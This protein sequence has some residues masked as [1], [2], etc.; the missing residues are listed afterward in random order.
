MKLAQRYLWQVWDGYDGRSRGLELLP[1]VLSEA[2]VRVLP[3]AGAGISMTLDELR[4]PLGSSD[5]SAAR[6]ERLQTTLGEGPCLDAVAA[7]EPRMFC[8]AA[9]AERWPVFHRRVITETPYRSIASVPLHPT[10]TACVGALDLYFTES[11]QVPLDDIAEVSAAIG[12]QISGLLFES[13]SKA[14]GAGVTMP[15][16]LSGDSVVDRMNV[17]VAV[18]ILIEHADLT[19][20]DALSALRAYAFAHDLSLDQVADD[21][22]AERLPPAALLG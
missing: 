5:G 13:P 14:F 4:V 10:E 21:L 18:A 15:I 11:E 6:V 7:A 3:V 16:W 12:S 8:E 22:T 19:N 20:P 2:C 9:L 1:T 17:W